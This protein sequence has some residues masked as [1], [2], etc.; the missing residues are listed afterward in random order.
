MLYNI[1]TFAFGTNKAQ[2]AEEVKHD[3]IVKKI[4][5]DTLFV[6]VINKSA[7]VS[8]SVQ[9]ACNVS[10]MAEKIIEVNRYGVDFDIGEK[11]VV[12]L[13]EDSGLRALFLGYIL[14]FILVM[15]SMIIGTS[16]SEDELQIGL[17]SLLILVPYYV[18]LYFLRGRLKKQFSFFVYKC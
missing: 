6:S 14:P 2:M 3:G 5:G 16:F 4:E 9:E 15:T 8:C 17:I 11:V 7:C 1:Y 13:K 12:A 10:E 18:S